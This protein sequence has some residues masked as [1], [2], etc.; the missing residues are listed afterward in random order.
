VIEA[1]H[2]FDKVDQVSVPLLEGLPRRAADKVLAE[3]REHACLRWL[4]CF[5]I[6]RA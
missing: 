2:D 4:S 3:G 6:G 1:V 5:P